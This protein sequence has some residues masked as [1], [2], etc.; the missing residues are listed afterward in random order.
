MVCWVEPSAQNCIYISNNLSHKIPAKLNSF[1]LWPVW[2]LR[3]QARNLRVLTW[4]LRGLSDPTVL[5]VTVGV[6]ILTP[7]P[8]M[9]IFFTHSSISKESSFSLQAWCSQ[10]PYSNLCDSLGIWL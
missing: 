7:S 10:L 6:F 3:A 2:N 5:W 9:V 8:P 1:L 4:R